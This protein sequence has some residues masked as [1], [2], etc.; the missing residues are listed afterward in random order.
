MKNSYKY[1]KKEHSVLIS[2]CLFIILLICVAF[3][4]RFI[5][6]VG[7]DMREY[8]NNLPEE[9]TY[10][11]AEAIA[12]S[13][14]DMEEYWND[15][16]KWVNFSVA[17]SGSSAVSAQIGALICAAKSGDDAGYRRALIF[18]DL[19]LDDV[20]RPERFTIENIF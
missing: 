14:S 5:N 13:A 19:A 9:L 3:N 1:N 20:C 11:N 18:F 8:R 7:D 2:V 12:K 6:G 4:N 10:G 17:K 15:K 16:R